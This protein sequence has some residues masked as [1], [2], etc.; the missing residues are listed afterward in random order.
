MNNSRAVS[1]SPGFNRVALPETTTLTHSGGTAP[2][3]HRTSLLCP[4]GH[5]RLTVSLNECSN[6]KEKLV[7]SAILSPVPFPVSR[8][9]I[10]CPAATRWY[11]T[12]CP[13][14]PDGT[15]WRGEKSS[16]RGRP[17]K[18]LKTA[19]NKTD[20][21]FHTFPKMLILPPLPPPL[22]P[23]CRK[24]GLHCLADTVYIGASLDFHA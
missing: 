20:S 17:L 21:T 5:L 18:R 10:R 16:L 15:H 23:R 24:S 11:S 19:G 9:D 12:P 8:V 3:S 14:S 2:V 13:S 4:C 7:A 1:P 6:C 22:L